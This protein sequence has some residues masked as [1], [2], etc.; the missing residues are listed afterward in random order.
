MTF[1]YRFAGKYEI[2]IGQEIAFPESL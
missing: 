1:G 2:A